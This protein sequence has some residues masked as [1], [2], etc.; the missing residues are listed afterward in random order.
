[1]VERSE[2]QPPASGGENA[3]VNED[4]RSTGDEG[5]RAAQA[6][7][8]IADDANAGQTTT[9]GEASDVGVPPDDELGEPAE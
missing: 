7:P 9:P 1:M 6:S 4:V 3:G 8:P 2:E 5:Q